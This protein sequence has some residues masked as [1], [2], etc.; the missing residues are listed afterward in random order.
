MKEAQQT[1]R[2]RK[3]YA[4]EQR[5]KTADLYL[6]GDIVSVPWMEGDVSSASLSRRLQELDAEEINV[7]IN[8]YGGEVAE[9]W[10]IY[11][12]LRQH[13][14]RVRTICDGF[15]CSAA[16]LVF[17]A[18]EERWMNPASMLMIHN[19]WQSVSGNAEELRKAAD[20]LEK[21]SQL[22]A[23]VYAEAVTLDE[24]ALN[25]LLSA[26]TWITPGEAVEWGFA[27]G[28]LEQQDTAGVHQCARNAVFQ[29]LTRR[30]TGPAP[31]AVSAHPIELDADFL[32]GFA[33][34]IRS[35]QEAAPASWM[36]RLRAFA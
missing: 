24:D 12:S 15:A 18:G 23:G 10:A 32:Q 25:A 16:S 3:F 6:F 11:N 31:V 13:P 34:G 2:S 14:G 9:G 26:E 4:L 35:Q 28:I 36:E 22:S 27:T 30:E 29:A 19:A 20:D 5:G 21:L 33:D 7:H 8:S 1:Q 17:M